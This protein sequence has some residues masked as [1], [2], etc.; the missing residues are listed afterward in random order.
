MRLSPDRSARS[1]REQRI[2]KEGAIAIA[3]GLEVKGSLT[4]LNLEYNGIGPEGAAAIAKGLTDNG[5]LTQVLAFSLES[6]I[7]IFCII[8]H[9]SIFALL[10]CHAA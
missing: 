9:S 8:L 1:L 10:V 5:S 7:A 3:E 4:E 2:D 6:A